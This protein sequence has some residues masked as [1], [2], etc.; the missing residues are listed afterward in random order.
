MFWVRSF[1]IA[2][3]KTQ[4]ETQVTTI[5]PD[6]EHNREQ[7]TQ[8]EALDAQQNIYF[9]TQTGETFRC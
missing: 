4:I 9:V 7:K 6:D 5:E 1:F 2:Q 8:S 3:D